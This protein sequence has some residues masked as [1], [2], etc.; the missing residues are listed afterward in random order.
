MTLFAVDLWLATSGVTPG[1]MRGIGD[2]VGEAASWRVMADLFFLAF[3]GG[4]FSVPLYALI[5]SRA[6]ATHRARIIAA[7]NILNALFMIV[8]SVMAKL[9]LDAAPPLPQRFLVVGIMNPAV[10]V[11]SYR[12]VPGFLS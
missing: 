6:E 4:L 1:P 7:N 5:Q 10:A 9:L 12:Q 11:H 8:A 3:F 2:F